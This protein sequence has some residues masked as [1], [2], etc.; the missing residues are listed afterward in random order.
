[1]REKFCEKSLLLVKRKSQGE[2][3]KIKEIKAFVASKE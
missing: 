2:R 3:D 1:M